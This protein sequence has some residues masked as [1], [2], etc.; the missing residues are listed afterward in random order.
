MND[1]QIK[2]VNDKLTDDYLNEVSKRIVIYMCEK[3]MPL[4]SIFTENLFELIPRCNSLYDIVE[5]HKE[6]TGDDG[7]K[8]YSAKTCFLILNDERGTL[9]GSQ[10]TFTFDAVKMKI[11]KNYILYNITW[12][13]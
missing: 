7:K 3:N 5:W 13:K 12:R 6:K 1:R 2:K 10:L 11:I 8:W 4:I 9:P